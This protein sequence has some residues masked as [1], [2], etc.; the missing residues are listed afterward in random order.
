MGFDEAGEDGGARKVDDARSGRR[1]CRGGVAHTLDAVAAD[2]DDLVGARLVALAVNELP[3]ADDDN[4]GG[5]G[6]GRRLCPLGK[7]GKTSGGN[8]QQN[9]DASGAHEHLEHDGMRRTIN[10]ARGGWQSA[11]GGR[12][13]D[14]IAPRPQR[15]I[16]SAHPGGCAEG[17]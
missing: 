14:P 11:F 10:P 2:D 9:G 1:V 8:Q 12:C 5:S 4:L 13:R 17:Y 15:V 3:G 6:G 7:L 16:E